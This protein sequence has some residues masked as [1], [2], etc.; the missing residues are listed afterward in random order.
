M[1]RRNL[2]NWK[3]AELGQLEAKIKSFCDRENVHAFVQH[4]ILFA[5]K[6]SELQK[7]VLR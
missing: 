2:F 4:Y 1:V 6:E 3:H 5:E 7:F